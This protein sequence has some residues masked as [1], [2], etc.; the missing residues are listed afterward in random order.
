MWRLDNR[1]IPGFK[2][3]FP[4]KKIIL[5]EGNA[6]YHKAQSTEYYPEGKSPDYAT[7]GLNAHVDGGRT[8]YPSKAGRRNQFAHRPD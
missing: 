2:K 7:K 3:K 4:G 8:L 5:I 1:L 6:P